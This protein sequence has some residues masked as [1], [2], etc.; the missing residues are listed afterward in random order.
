V[1][2]DDGVGFVAWRRNRLFADDDVVDVLLTVKRNPETTKL[3]LFNKDSENTATKRRN[4][5]KLVLFFF[6]V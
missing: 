3:P 4:A 1:V 6:F 5:V 2:L